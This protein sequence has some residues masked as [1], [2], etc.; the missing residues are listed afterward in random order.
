MYEAEFSNNIIEIIF[1][2]FFLKLYFYF[3]LKKKFLTSTSLSLGKERISGRKCPFF[4][5]KKD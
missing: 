4:G 3:N 1:N 2:N 5:K